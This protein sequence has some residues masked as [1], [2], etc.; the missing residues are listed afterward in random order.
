MFVVF[1]FWTWEIDIIRVRCKV[2][3]GI[4]QTYKLEECHERIKRPVG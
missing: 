2:D 4:T 1:L 3:V